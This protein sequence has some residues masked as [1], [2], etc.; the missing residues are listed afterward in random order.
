MVG[1]PLVVG[2]CLQVLEQVG[3][4][5]G[6]AHEVGGDDAEEA[7]AALTRVGVWRLV[8]GRLLHDLAVDLVAQTLVLVTMLTKHPQIRHRVSL[9]I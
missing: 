3:L 9:K 5:R 1:S 6:R 4:E 2:G 8:V 7:P